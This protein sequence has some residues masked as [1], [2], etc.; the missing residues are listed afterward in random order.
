MKIKAE[1]DLERQRNEAQ[2]QLW[3]QA[4]E[5]VLKLGQ[6]VLGKTVDDNDNQRLIDQA[7]KRLSKEE[8]INKEI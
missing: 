2:A 7:I 6:D 4:G 1:A 8:S 3:V 5:I